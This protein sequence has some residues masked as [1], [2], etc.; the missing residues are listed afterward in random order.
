MAKRK[1]YREGF[2]R[3]YEIGV[4]DVFEEIRDNDFISIDVEDLAPVA[5]ACGISDEEFKAI[6]GISEEGEEEV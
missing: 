3:G 5:E 2:D 6:I 4:R 1:T